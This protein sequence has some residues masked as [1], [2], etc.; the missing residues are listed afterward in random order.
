MQSVF[1]EDEEIVITSVVDT[2]DGFVM[3]G[4]VKN[5]NYRVLVLKTNKSG[6]LEW[7]KTYGH[8]SVDYEGQNIVAIDDGFL[9]CGCS[10]GHASECGGRDWKAYLLQVNSSGEKQWQRSFRI[11]GNEC[12]FS[13]VVKENILLFGETRDPSGNS[14]LFL[15]N[16]DNH[17]EEI[18]RRTYC[19]EEDVM[20]GGIVPD[21]QGHILA[22]SL[23]RNGRWYLYL[24]KVDRDGR[25]I[26][27]KSYKDALVYDMCSGEDGIF[28]TGM[29]GEHIYLVKINKK[30]EIVWDR[31]YDNGCGVT[32]DCKKDRIMIAGEIE[33]GESCFP[34]LYKISEDGIVEWKRVYDKEGVI[35][36]V[37]QLDDGYMLIRHGLTPKEHT[38]IIQVGKDG[39]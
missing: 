21:D 16:L 17:G 11:K 22:G 29:R 18:W 26:W 31:T 39:S 13:L 3:V 4:S 19:C 15:L 24:S 1:R 30:G 12:A 23:M 38:E 7:R 14:H 32:I 5:D 9:I 27:E 35:E 36:K 34:V 20:A 8:S 37:K 6:E 28:L 25:K 10:E 2:L 33:V